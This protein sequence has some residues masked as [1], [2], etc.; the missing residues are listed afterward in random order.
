MLKLKSKELQEQLHI[1]EPNDRELE[2]AIRNLGA[3]MND[4][5]RW[6]EDEVCDDDFLTEVRSF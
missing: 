4:V 3:K 6:T 5:A 2:V 1:L